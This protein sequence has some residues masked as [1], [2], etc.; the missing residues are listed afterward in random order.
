VR[1]W[2]LP[3]DSSMRIISLSRSP[4]ASPAMAL[5]AVSV[6]AAPA[7]APASNNR[8]QLV[9]HHRLP[10][11][12]PLGSPLR[13]RLLLR[14]QPLPREPIPLQPP[15]HTIL[16][17]HTMA[18]PVERIRMPHMVDMLPTFSTVCIPHLLHCVHMLTQ[19]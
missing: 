9:G 11:L 8:N 1:I 18:T 17:L 19:L 15:P 2:S 16:T 5:V 6:A 7:T 3:F 4:R 10:H 14:L 12:L 13:H